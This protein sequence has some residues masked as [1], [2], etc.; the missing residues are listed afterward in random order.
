VVVLPPPT[1][2]VNT[3]SVTLKVEQLM[4]SSEPPP[5]TKANKNASMDEVIMEVL[6]HLIYTKQLQVF[7]A[8]TRNLCG[9][10]QQT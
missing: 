10:Y 3:P 1:L 5:T 7:Y 8:K 4:I 9:S 6:R 2:Q